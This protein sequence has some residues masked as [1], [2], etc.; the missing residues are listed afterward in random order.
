MDIR[1]KLVL[2]LTAAFY[3]LVLILPM[4]MPGPQ[5]PDPLA[6]LGSLV[7]LDVPLPPDPAMMDPLRQEASAALDALQAGRQ[8]TR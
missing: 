2:L 5:Q 8:T 1:R 4:L 7:S 6:P 3:S